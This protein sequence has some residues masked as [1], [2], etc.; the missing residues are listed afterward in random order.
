MNQE[1]IDAAFQAWLNGPAS[2]AGEWTEEDLKDAFT[3][4]IKFAQ[5]DAA[6]GDQPTEGK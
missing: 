3:A 2:D 1:Q 4:G 6:H 5:S